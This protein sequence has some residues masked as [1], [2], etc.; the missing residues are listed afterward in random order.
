MG[1]SALVGLAG[2]GLGA[3]G[4]YQSSAAQG[5]AE[6]RYNE[7]RVQSENLLAQRRSDFQRTMDELRGQIEGI[8]PA[9][10]S[11][12]ELKTLEDKVNFDTGQ[13]GQEL[14]TSLIQSVL[15]RNINPNSGAVAGAAGELAR[16]LTEF[17]SGKLLDISAASLGQKKSEEAAKKNTMRSY[18]SALATGQNDLNNVD[19]GNVQNDLSN[20]TAIQGQKGKQFGDLSSALLSS[21]SDVDTSD[22]LKINSGVTYLK[23]L[24]KKK[25]KQVASAE[26]PDVE[27]AA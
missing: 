25:P 10:Y 5:R 26:S 17:K 4:A 14:S 9:G 2:L 21:I 16:K 6:S 7:A 11:P 13:K 15:G 3:Y 22:P 12:D 20:F 18:L 19:L 1:A 24:L 8:T 23:N 27:Y